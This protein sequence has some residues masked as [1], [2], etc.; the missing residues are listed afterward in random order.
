MKKLKYWIPSILYALV[1][2]FLS[3]R[4]RI[5]ITHQFIFD[6]A[7]FKSI[8]MIEYAIFFLIN[9]RAFFNTLNNKSYA[10]LG[11]F[12]ITIIYAL[13]D[14]LHQTFI[15]TR[16]GKLR[17]IG[18]DTIGVCLALIFVWKLLPKAPGKLLIW[19]KKLEII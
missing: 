13:S 18:F 14:E 17:D 11:A 19:A 2:F 16:E 12:F 3:S 10:R 9:Y 5:S 1:I 8:H 7:I 6:F 15:P 4:Q